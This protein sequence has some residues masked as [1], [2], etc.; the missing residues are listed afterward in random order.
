MLNDIDLKQASPAVQ[1]GSEREDHFI[2]MT[3]NILDPFL[4]RRSIPRNMDR[5]II[6]RLSEIKI[7]EEDILSFS[8]IGLGNGGSDLYT[9][10]QKEYE[11]NF[12]KGVESS[13]KLSDKYFKRE[14]LWDTDVRTFED[15]KN[16][17]R[18]RD[19]DHLIFSGTPNEFYGRINETKIVLRSLPYYLDR[20]RSSSTSVSLEEIKLSDNIGWDRRGNWVLAK[21][22]DLQK[23]DR[24]PDIIFLQE[25]GQVHNLILP[26][27]GQT[28]LA[29]LNDT[30]DFREIYDYQFYIHPAFDVERAAK[31]NVE[32]LIILYKRAKFSLWPENRVVDTEYNTF[33]RCIDLDSCNP[34]PDMANVIDHKWA[35]ILKLRIR[36]TDRYIVLVNTHLVT[37]TRDSAYPRTILA[38]EKS[39]Y[40]EEHSRHLSDTSSGRNK[41]WEFKYLLNYMFDLCAFPGG[42]GPSDAIIVGG[43]FNTRYRVVRDEIYGDRNIFG[44]LFRGTVRLGPD[45]LL[46]DSY[47]SSDVIRNDSRFYTSG[48]GSGAKIIDYI[49]H[50]ENLQCRSVNILRSDNDNDIDIPNRE[51]PSDHLPVIA[52]FTMSNTGS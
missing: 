42:I 43:D 21:L 50:S 18:G 28:L 33:S 40:F 2:V 32:G 4:S 46:T 12:H 41:R 25:Y 51:N 17:K 44:N 14:E 23:S 9:V 5:K 16:L 52:T 48:K 3:W 49:F 1:N 22:R 26:G 38:D 8:G 19:L 29:A 37:D 39:V 36:G 31:Q 10:L 34:W 11:T 45:R 15:F 30:D 27:Y 24:P 35:G 6:S 7:P 20:Y 13:S 47:M